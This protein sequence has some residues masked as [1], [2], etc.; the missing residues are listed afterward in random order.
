MQSFKAKLLIL[1]DVLH[2]P[3]YHSNL[4]RD[5]AELGRIIED[6]DGFSDLLPG[7]V[8]GGVGDE[9]VDGVFGVVH[10]VSDLLHQLLERLVFAP[11][12]RGI[13]EESFEQGEIVVE[14]LHLI[15]DVEN[16]VGIVEQ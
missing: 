5:A 6:M 12:L 1:I 13:L 2:L 10:H 14:E 7:L 15:L 4:I 16:E 8:H 9:S 11:F 3:P